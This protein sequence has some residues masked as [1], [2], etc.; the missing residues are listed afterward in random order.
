MI[1]V[2]LKTREN[3]DVKLKPRQGIKIDSSNKYL[4]DPNLVQEYVDLTK[5]YSDKAM[6]SEAN[7]KASEMNAELSA[8]QAKA[9]EDNAKLSETRAKESELN[10]K[11]S[12]NNAKES[13]TKAR[14]EA[15]AS[16][17][18]AYQSQQSALASSQYA[19]NAESDSQNA[20]ETLEHVLESEGRAK[21]YSDL[22][23][24]SSV[25]AIEK[26]EEVKASVAEAKASEV[27][28]KSSEINAKASE[29]KAIQEANASAESAYQSQQSALASAEYASNA[30]SDAQ[31]VN[32]TLGLVLDAETRVTQSEQ[33]IKEYSDNA[34]A[35]SEIATE[36]A[37]I[38][39]TKASESLASANKAE[40]SAK[41]SS[42]SASLSLEYSTS[43]GQSASSASLS[44]S[45]ASKSE[46]NAKTSETN[47]KTSENNS[48]S[49]ET[50]ASQS[51]TSASNSA[52]TAK[53][54]A[55]EASQFALE[56]Q[57]IKDS[58]GSVYV[59]RGSVNTASE[60]PNNAKVG[61]VYDAKDTGVNYAW[62]GTEWDALGVTIDFDLSEY[63]TKEYVNTTEQEII[64]NY[65]E[66]DTALQTQITSLS[67]VDDGEQEKIIGIES[68]IPT[69][70][71]SSNLLVTNTDMFNATQDVR[72]DFAEAD[73]ELQ[74]Q[75]NGQATAISGKQDKLTAGTGISID[76]NVISNTQTSAEWGNIKG[77][78]S[79]QTDLQNALN[80]KQNT[81]VSGTNIKTVNGE[82]LLGGGDV[83]ITG[84]IT[85]EDLNEDVTVNPTPIREEW[86]TFRNSIYDTF[87]PIG[88]IYMGVQETCPMASL[89]SGSV[90]EL[91][92]TDRVLQGS[93]STHIAG[94]TINA[95]LPNIT[96]DIY[97]GS[98]YGS[99]IF[100]SSSGAMQNDSN[101]GWRT[102]TTQNTVSGAS[103]RVSFDASRSN[104]I[105][106]KSSTVQPPAYV[107]NIWQRTA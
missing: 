35:K 62:T 7:A 32:E 16:A 29:Q 104:S 39:T 58:L 71:S 105:Y 106:G 10:A 83:E 27:N 12:E 102:I 57:T 73:S 24:A 78:L 43:A 54:K 34:S 77:T 93:S 60:L 13:E 5:D 55:D 79:N 1:K 76:N 50:N 100:T 69:S 88:S 9:S 52:K 74:T 41:N 30:E 81:L 46:T 8:E 70:A 99:S 89:I 2:K 6:Q 98:T 96:G 19:S 68:K 103:D 91:V 36:K 25:I 26:T 20:L 42:D 75:I 33:R 40:Q 86:E 14:Q 65:M 45:N 53:E 66:A 87:Y 56:C 23:Q 95:G 80:N 85:Y 94:S 97:A 37:E 28:A 101:S 48:K 15:N 4:F 107:V 17:E 31:N 49:S 22:A 72:A 67:T 18:S 92:A 21:N 84:G 61:D 44:S 64:E 47:A 3:I 63:A 90:W 51:A 38:A 82:S 11:T 59:F